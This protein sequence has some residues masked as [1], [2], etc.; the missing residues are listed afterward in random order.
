MSLTYQPSVV[1]E[2]LA[3]RL[4]VAARKPR[5]D[6]PTKKGGK[7]THFRAAPHFFGGKIGKNFTI[8]KIETYRGEEQSNSNGQRSNLN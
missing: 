2:E 3:L 6:L 1:H 8:K 5:F 4:Y 7:K